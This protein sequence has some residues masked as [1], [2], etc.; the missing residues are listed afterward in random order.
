VPPLCPLLQK[1]VFQG[2]FSRAAGKSLPALGRKPV[3]ALAAKYGVH[4]RL[5]REG[6]TRAQRSGQPVAKDDA[7]DGI[8]WEFAVA[9]RLP[10]TDR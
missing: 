3:R 4:R 7:E 5:D 10:T 9:W 6:L 8:E 1:S 2:L